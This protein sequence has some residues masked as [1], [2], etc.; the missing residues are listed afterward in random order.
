MKFISKIKNCI[1]LIADND[2]RLL[3]FSHYGLTSWISDEKFLTQRYRA[4][5]GRELNLENPITYTE[6]L[7]WLKAYDHRPEY[8]TMVDKYAVKKYVSDKIGE[9][10]VIPL[11]GVW[12]RVEDIDFS[13][14][15]NRFVLKASHD[16]GDLVVCKDKSQLD[17]PKIKK[18]FKKLLKRNYYWGTREWPY[19]NVKPRIIAEA[20]MEDSTYRELRDYKFFTFGGVPKVLYIAQGR[21]KGDPTVADFFDMDFNH[22]PFTIDHDMAAVPPQKPKCFEEMK[23]LAAVLSEGTPQL[24]VDFY[25]VDGRVYFGEMTFFHCSGFEAF[26]PEEWDRIFGDWVTLPPKTAGEDRNDDTNQ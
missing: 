15:P 2:F 8:T 18:S 23:R 21:G 12:D 13:T 16:S 26:H 4:E 22:L 5:M 20:Y 17:I 24:R 7:Q 11:I 1:R 9:K 25:E 6:K 19:K 10:Y 14:L 3:F